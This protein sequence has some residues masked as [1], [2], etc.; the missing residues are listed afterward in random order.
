MIDYIINTL[1]AIFNNEGI[2]KD[3]PK[4]ELSLTLVSHALTFVCENDYHF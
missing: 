1:K 3:P 4:E 2:R